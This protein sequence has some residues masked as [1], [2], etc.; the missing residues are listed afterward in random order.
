METLEKV[1]LANCINPQKPHNGLK[2]LIQALIT[3]R[4]TLQYV[5]ISGNNWNKDMAVVD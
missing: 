3:N 2:Y 1:N 5:D 4:A